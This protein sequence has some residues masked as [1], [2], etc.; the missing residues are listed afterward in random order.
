MLASVVT[1]I[2]GIVLS[3]IMQSAGWFKAIAGL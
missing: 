1:S 3:A 2:Y